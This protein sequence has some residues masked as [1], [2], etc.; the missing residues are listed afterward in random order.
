MEENWVIEKAKLE[1]EKP[2]P[3]CKEGNKRKSL[4][5]AKLST[6][7]AMDI[8][9]VGYKSMK[10]REVEQKS[11]FSCNVDLQRKKERKRCYRRWRE[12]F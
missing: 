6:Q 1:E 3:K 2:K 9:N 4:Y 7:K 11:L 8:V 10:G 12:Q 5:D